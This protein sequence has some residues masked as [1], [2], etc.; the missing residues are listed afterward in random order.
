[1]IFIDAE[2]PIVLT[3]SAHDHVAVGVAK[4]GKLHVPFDED[5]S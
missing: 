2:K 3:K 5:F 4:V 1:M